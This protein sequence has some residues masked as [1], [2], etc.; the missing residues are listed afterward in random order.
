MLNSQNAAALL[1]VDTYL[2]REKK[3]PICDCPVIY[4][5][6]IDWARDAAKAIGVTTIFES[7]KCELSELDGYEIVIAIKANTIIRR[8]NMRSA[9]AQF[10]GSIAM[11]ANGVIIAQI[12]TGADY[13]AHKDDLFSGCCSTLHVDDSYLL[14]NAMDVYRVNEAMRQSIIKRHISNGVIFTDLSGV[15]IGRDTKI[16]AGT[17][18]L[19]GSVI[20]GDSVIGGGCEIGPGC[21][22]ND[23]AVGDGV[24]LLHVIANGAVI[25]EGCTVGP[26]TQLR[27]G[28][29]LGKGVKIGDFVEIK[30]SNIGDGTSVAHLTYVGDSDVGVHCNFGCGVAVAN[31]DGEKKSRTRVGDYCFIGCNTNLIAPVSLGDGAFTAAGS[32]ITQDVPADSLGIERADQRIVQGY[33]KRKLSAY[34]KKHKRQ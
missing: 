23:T 20:I 17:V 16:A 9:A 28:A 32:T 12:Y 21:H 18:V 33:S 24:R 19:P 31:Y 4:K 13:R 25:G 10:N 8:S 14:N 15:V 1:V 34:F 6:A 29:V 22:L 26:Y 11:E 27:P 5:K 7:D 30:N 3:L 2:D